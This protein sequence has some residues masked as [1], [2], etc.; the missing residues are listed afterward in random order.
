M[1]DLQNLHR[2]QL[3]EHLKFSLNYLVFIPT[4]PLISKQLPKTSIFLG[5]IANIS[6][7]EPVILKTIQSL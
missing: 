3:I 6:K 2:R 5:V 4:S 7:P 1:F